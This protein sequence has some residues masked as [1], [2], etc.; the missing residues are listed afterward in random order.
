MN[1]RITWNP[2]VSK[3][4]KPQ[5]LLIL[6]LGSILAGPLYAEEERPFWRETVDHIWH[7]QRRMLTSP[8]RV[9]RTDLVVWGTAA[10]TLLYFA[11]HWSH[12]RSPDERLEQGIDRR[13]KAFLRDFTHTG[14]APVLIGSSLLAYGIGYW[15]DAPRL[16]TG[17]LH[18][19]EGLIDTGIALSLIKVL[20]G[21]TRPIHRPTDSRFL[22]PGGYFENSSD[23]SSFPSGHSAMSFAA[24][25]IVSHEAGTYWVGIPA[26]A[27]AGG[28]AYSRI[29]VEKH[30]FSDVV[31]GAAL[32][33]SIGVLV[34][35][36]RHAKPEKTGR[37][38]PTAGEDWIGLAWSRSW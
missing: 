2:P 20:A 27:L 22:G 36:H 10:G 32:G 29:Y 25:T 1:R 34:E 24:A 7:D 9:N 17:S 11:P 5:S 21:R 14:D 31:A 28:I 33:Y 37:I 13:D 35:K 12:R 23:N 8:L 26:Y 6:L 4:L 3:R 30:W 19:F 18:V 38:Y 16:K 15:Q